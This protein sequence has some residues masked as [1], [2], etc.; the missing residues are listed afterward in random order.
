[1][2]FSGQRATRTGCLVNLESQEKI[3]SV[4]CSDTQF[5]YEDSPRLRRTADA[6]GSLKKDAGASFFAGFGAATTN[7]QTPGVYAKA[8]LA[9][10]ANQPPQITPSN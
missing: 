9:K 5:F 3:M 8:L 10:T 2:H 4:I 6:E 1:M 7:E